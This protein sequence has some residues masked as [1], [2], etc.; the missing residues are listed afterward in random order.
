MPNLYNLTPGGLEVYNYS[1]LLYQL[2]KSDWKQTI[3]RLGH[4]SSLIDQ[5]HKYKYI[6]VKMTKC[7]KLNTEQ[8]IHETHMI[9]HTDKY[10]ICG[11]P[12]YNLQS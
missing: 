3:H 9:I 2:L 11:D 8:I 10:L 1:T 5:I 6:Y 12:I 7:Y 4:I